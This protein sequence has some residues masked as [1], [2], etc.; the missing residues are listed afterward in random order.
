[1]KYPETAKGEQTVS[2]LLAA[3]Y[4]RMPESPKDFAFLA[5]CPVGTFSNS[6]SQ[7]AEGCT[8][9]PPGNFG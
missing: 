8:P 3:G 1:M 2:A 9:C 6:S 7:G 4:T 5:P